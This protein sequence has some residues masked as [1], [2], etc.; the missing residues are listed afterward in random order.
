MKKYMV[1]RAPEESERDLTKYELIGVEYGEDIYD[2]TDA[3]IRAVTT[4]IIED[5]AYAGCIDVCA[6]GP[7]RMPE[8]HR[9]KGYQ[10]YLIGSFA[11][12]NAGKNTLVEYSVI[13]TEES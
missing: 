5:P 8:I 9:T 12:P 2:V 11:M 3:L 4:D 1:Y 6:H 7:D 13:E 10:Y